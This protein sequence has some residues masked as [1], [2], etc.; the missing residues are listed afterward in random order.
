MIATNPWS[1]HVLGELIPEENG[2]NATMKYRDYWGYEIELLKA[3][4]K[5][6]DFTYTIVNPEDG[7]WGH[8]E[9]DGTWSG[10][11]W[12][13]ASGAVDFVICDIFIVYSRQ[14]VFDGTIPFDKD[15]QVSKNDSDPTLHDQHSGRV[16]SVLIGLRFS[17]ATSSAKISLPSESIYRVGVASSVL[18]CA[19]SLFHNVGHFQC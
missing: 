18:F 7:L 16:H 6:L 5:S 10:L 8:I 2:G 3:L 14:Q 13:A 15:Y 1:H 19:G 17:N 11:V 4:S 12:E 9:A